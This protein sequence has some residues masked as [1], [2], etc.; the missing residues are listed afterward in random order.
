MSVLGVGN[1]LVDA[2]VLLEDDEFLSNLK[3]EKGSMNLVNFENY[4]EI[5]AILEGSK[6]TYVAGGS[7][8]NSIV[9]LGALGLSV[10]FLG[11]VGEDQ[12]GEIFRDSFLSIGVIPH[13]NFD[14]GNTGIATTFISKDAERTFATYLGVAGNLNADK[15]SSELKDYEILYI[16]G[17]LV[18]D[19]ELLQSLIR[20]GREAG[21]K[22]ALDLA[23]FNVVEENREFLLEN[24]PGNIDILFANE[25]EA[26]SLTG[27][28]PY[29]GVKQISSWA[30]I[31][32]IKMGA[33][34]SLIQQ[35]ENFYEVKAKPVPKCVDATGAG[36]LYASGFLY[37][38]CQSYP[39][40]ICGE[41]GSILAAEVIQQIGPKIPLDVWSEIKDQIATI[42]KKIK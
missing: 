39:L 29:Q 36:D 34:G 20:K 12:F 23:S 24:L 28:D 37:G 3:L 16:E 4:K 5:T 2:L 35:G 33:K 31:A 27:I 1:A 19:T 15:L 10:G 25:Q 26:Y 42:E 30:D 17:Y 14:N 22:I 38:I 7:V 18:Q 41:I 21:L 6:V 9:G 32:V 11:N 13:L 8:A 40:D